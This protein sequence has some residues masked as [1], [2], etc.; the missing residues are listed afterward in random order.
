[1]GHILI[2]NDYSTVM[3]E[4]LAHQS[5]QGFFGMLTPFPPMGDDHFLGDPWDEAV[6]K[7]QK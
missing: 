1:M 4:T 7:C 6:L 5:N 2:Q 3:E